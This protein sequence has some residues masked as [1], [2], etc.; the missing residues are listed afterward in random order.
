[1]P[2]RLELWE[3]HERIKAVGCEA[4]FNSAYD[5]KCRKCGTT[6][7]CNYVRLHGSE[8]SKMMSKMGP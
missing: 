8:M 2:H 1:M 6:P 5:V 7:S 3:S 4:W